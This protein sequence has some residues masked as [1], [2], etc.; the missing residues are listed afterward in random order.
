M[1]HIIEVVTSCSEEYDDT[2]HLLVFVLFLFHIYS[3]VGSGYESFINGFN[4]TTLPST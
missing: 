1:D 4:I 3:K 2:I